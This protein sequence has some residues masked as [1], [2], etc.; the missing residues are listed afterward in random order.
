M[1]LALAIYRHLPGMTMAETY[2]DI[3]VGYTEQ[4]AES[5]RNGQRLPQPTPQNC[6]IIT[7]Q[8][9]F[10]DK[11]ELQIFK[12]W[13]SSEEEIIRKAYSI[14]NPQSK[15]DIIPVG[16]NILFDLGMLRARASQYG[17]NYS[18]WFIYNDL[19]KIDIK[20][21][22]MGMNAFTFKNSGLDKFTGKESS[23]INIPVWYAN[24]E[25]EKILSYIRKESQ[26]FIDF[27]LKLKTLLPEFRKQHG[28]FHTV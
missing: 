21:I 15:W 9:Q 23:G 5:I 26:E 14:I 8:Y 2:F 25:F 3:E 6:K 19:P 22:L 7:I 18:E 11:G 28:F 10:V 4:F 24:R 1:A 16:Q 27:Y 20:A 13:E 12:E 17:I